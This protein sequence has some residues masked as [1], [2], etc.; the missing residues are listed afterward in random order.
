MRSQYL[1]SSMFSS[2]NACPGWVL[3]N[4]GGSDLR[5]SRRQVRLAAVP[6]SSWSW[7]SSRFVLELTEDEERDPL[8]D[9]AVST[10]AAVGATSASLREEWLR[11]WEICSLPTPHLDLLRQPDA[12]HSAPMATL[13]MGSSQISSF[14]WRCA[15][16]SPSVCYRRLFHAGQPQQPETSHSVNASNARPGRLPFIPSVA[17][18]LQYCLLP[19]EQN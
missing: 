12:P 3:R 5:L 11:R 19:T 8:S 6:P 18:C 4:D 14:S 17:C 9:R 16:S 15:V 10:V 1:L 13:V 2:N 7:S